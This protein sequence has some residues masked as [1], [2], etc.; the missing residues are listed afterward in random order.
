MEKIIEV[1]SC[2][3]KQGYLIKTDKMS[4]YMFVY[5]YP[6]TFETNCPV[7]CAYIHWFVSPLSCFKFLKMNCFFLNLISKALK[8]SYKL[9]RESINLNY[10][11]YWNAVNKLTLITGLCQ[12]TGRCQVWFGNMTSPITE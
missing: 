1:F 12:I 10:L 4:F 9:H 6:S 3:L 8:F 11:I 2:N 7:M 5:M